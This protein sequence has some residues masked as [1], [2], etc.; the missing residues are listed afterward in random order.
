MKRVLVSCLVAA[1][2]D[3]L[4]AA[5]DA[6]GPTVATI[7]LDPA[8]ADWLFLLDRSSTWT[9][10]EERFAGLKEGVSAFVRAVEAH[11]TFAVTSFSRDGDSC[12]VAAYATPEMAWG[13]SARDVAGLL[14]SWNVSGQSTLGPALAGAGLAA[15]RRRWDAPGHSTSIVVLTDAAP[16]E[17]EMCPT[18]DWDE[19]A[20]ISGRIFAHGRGPTVHLVNVLGT[21]TSPDHPGIVGA[22]AVAGGGYAAFVNG[23]RS[24]IARA[25]QTALHDLESRA[26]T[27]TRL[28]P[29]GFVPEHMTMTSGDGTITELM[30]VAD[31]SACT[32]GTPTAPQPSFFLDDPVAPTTATLCGGIGGVGGFC[33]TTFLRARVLGAPTFTATRRLQ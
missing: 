8:P 25:A 27:C 3:G 32:G 11:N 16:G 18:S 26:T 14:S 13:A 29:A 12:D 4:S 10:R 6:S 22:I 9:E 17:D 5:P 7:E 20:A 31:A 15:T 21:A 33:E 28:V 30:R 2:G 19:V 24:D 23:G 1:C